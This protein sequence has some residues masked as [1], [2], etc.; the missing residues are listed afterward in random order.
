MQASICIEVVSS[1]TW[2]RWARAQA[3]LFH[4]LTGCRIAEDG[5]W[6][7][8]ASSDAPVFVHKTAASEWRA[9][10]AGRTQQLPVRI[11]HGTTCIRMLRAHVADP[12]GCLQHMHRGARHLAEE[13]SVSLALRRRV[14][15]VARARVKW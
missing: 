14:V 11:G 8:G 7:F 15:R 12:A 4:V 2:A 10:V 1:P 13:N 6:Q 9:I 3:A 5:Q